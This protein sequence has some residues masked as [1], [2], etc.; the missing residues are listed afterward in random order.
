M[1]KRRKELDGRTFDALSDAEKAKIVAEIEAEDPADRLAR[2]KPLTPAQRA[3]WRTR[4]KMGR[5]KIGQGHKVV[6]ISLEAGLLKKADAYAKRHGLKR[7]QLVAQGLRNV[8]GG[9]DPSRPAA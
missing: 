5:P 4:K 3:D 1:V 2:S 6:S 8:I 7:A 9:S